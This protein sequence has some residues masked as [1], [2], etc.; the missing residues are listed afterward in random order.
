MSVTLEWVTA[1][2][3]GARVVGPGG[4]AADGQRAERPDWIVLELGHGDSGGVAIQ[5]TRRDVARLLARAT[6]AVSA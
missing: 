3:A 6:E 2:V 1:A 4:E 5:G